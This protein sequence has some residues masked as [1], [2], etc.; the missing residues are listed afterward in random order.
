MLGGDDFESWGEMKINFK[1]MKE[2]KKEVINATKKKG[3]S[4]LSQIA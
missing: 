1:E 4:S 3:P 2:N